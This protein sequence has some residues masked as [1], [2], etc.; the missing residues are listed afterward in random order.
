MPS[1]ALFLRAEVLGDAMKPIAFVSANQPFSKCV[2]CSPVL[3]MGCIQ[4]AEKFGPLLKAQGYTRLM[5]H[6]IGGQHWPAV[7]VQTDVHTGDRSLGLK[8]GMDVRGMWINAWQMS[9]QI[10]VAQADRSELAAS[11]SM[12]MELSGLEEIIYYVGSPETLRDPVREGMECLQPY[13]LPGASLAFDHTFTRW[14]KAAQPYWKGNEVERDKQVAKLVTKLRKAGHKVYIELR[15]C[16]GAPTV[17]GTIA[18]LGVDGRY[19]ADLEP[20][21]AFGEVQ[22]I[23]YGA[24]TAEDYR[25]WDKRITPVVGAWEKIEAGEVGKTEGTLNEFKFWG[26]TVV[27]R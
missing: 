22:R 7:P 13:L 5:H 16:I 1:L 19:H 17:D 23:G 25:S 18:E 20:Y 4:W 27:D 24:V 11:H 8:R 26:R 14:P 6:N 12:L 15:D 2:V 3:E 9:E 21:F 10:G